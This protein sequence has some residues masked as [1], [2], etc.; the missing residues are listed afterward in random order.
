MTRNKQW[1]NSKP[2]NGRKEE[3]R[4]EGGREGKETGK[5]GRVRQRQK[6]KN[7]TYPEGN[8]CYIWR[9]RILFLLSKV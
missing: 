8:L 5:E 1:A 7:R 4:K 6:W 9:D 3:E 2:K